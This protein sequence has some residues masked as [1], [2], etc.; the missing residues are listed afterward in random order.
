MAVFFKTP[1]PPGAVLRA[2]RLF[3]RPRV[4]GAAMTCVWRRAADG[5]LARIWEGPSSGSIASGEEPLQ[6]ALAS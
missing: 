5:K 6:L 1:A 4:R 3:V 2:E